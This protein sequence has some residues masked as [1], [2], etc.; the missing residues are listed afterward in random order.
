MG[1]KID[2]DWLLQKTDIIIEKMK[3]YAGIGTDMI[4]MFM[5]KMIEA[6]DKSKSIDILRGENDYE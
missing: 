4:P 5:N 6:Y 3:K 2:V 1:K